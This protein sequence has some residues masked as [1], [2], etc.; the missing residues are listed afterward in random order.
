MQLEQSPTTVVAFIV[1]RVPYKALNVETL[2]RQAMFN[3]LRD[4][5]ELIEKDMGRRLFQTV[6]EGRMPTMDDLLDEYGAVRLKRLM[7]AMCAGSAPTIVTHD[8]VDDARDPVLAHLRH[9][10]LWN[11]PEDRVKI[12][13]H[14]EFMSM[15]SPLFGMD[16]DQF[17]RGCHVGVFPS[18]YEPWGYTPMECIVRGIPAITS[19]LSGFGAYVMENFPDHHNGGMFVAR[20]RTASFESTVSQVAGWLHDLT[21][22]SRRERIALRNRVESHAEHFDWNNLGQYYAATRRLAFQRRYPGPDRV[23]E[24]PKEDSAATSP[25]KATT[26]Q[27]RSRRT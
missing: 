11:L 8:L 6:A 3:E 27:K 4:A 16:Y 23:P 5:C 26:R 15:T 2:N 13:F 22:M 19:D 1:T 20:R 21:R 7:Y 25:R 14:P 12:V 18:Y 24:A 10:G 17:V 9:R